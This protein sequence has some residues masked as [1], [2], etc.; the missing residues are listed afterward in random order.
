M[1]IRSSVSDGRCAI[2]NIQ[3][4]KPTFISMLATDIT[5]LLIMLVGLFR[6]RT[7]GGGWLDL[8][9]RLWKQ[10]SWQDALRN[11]D[12]VTLFQCDFR[13]RGCHLAL[14]CNHRRTLASGL[15]SH[16]SF[17]LRSTPLNI[18][19]VLGFESERY[20]VSPTVYL[21]TKKVD[22]AATNIR[23]V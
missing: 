21:R 23:C 6:L 4:S 12:D 7:P 18:S 13:P 14:A 19:G 11:T 3:S 20:L 8:G 17:I 15:S 9:R 16:P 2:M 10:V 5:L 1:Q 22:S